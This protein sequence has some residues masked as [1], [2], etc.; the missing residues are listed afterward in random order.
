MSTVYTTFSDGT[1]T[2]TLKPKDW[3][4]IPEIDNPSEE[5]ISPGAIVNNIEAARRKV[6]KIRAIQEYGAGLWISGNDITL[7]NT[8]IFYNW[9]I[10]AT[11][12]TYYNSNTGKT[13]TVKLFPRPQFKKLHQEA[14]V[15][16]YTINMVIQ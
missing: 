10:N 12:L 5:H 2:I 13:Y 16:G 3:S 14:I 6:K 11:S 7:T 1:T 8:D 9:Q 15:I 4:I